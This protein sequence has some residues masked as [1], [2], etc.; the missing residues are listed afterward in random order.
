[1]L[2]DEVAHAHP[3]TVVR[4]RLGVDQVPLGPGGSPRAGM[5]CRGQALRE[6]PLGGEEAA[7]EASKGADGDDDKG[8]K[9]EAGRSRRS[10]RRPY[11]FTQRKKKS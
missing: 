1:M 9:S 8:D 5:Q 10:S 3:Q 4:P 2:G 11:S 7:A 6:G